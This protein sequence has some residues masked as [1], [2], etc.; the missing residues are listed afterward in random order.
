MTKDTELFKKTRND[1]EKSEMP[2]RY[3]M[4]WAVVVDGANGKYR[5]IDAIAAE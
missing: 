1:M 5:D 3:V 4:A 2:R